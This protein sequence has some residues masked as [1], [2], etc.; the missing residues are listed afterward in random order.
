MLAPTSTD[1][2]IEQACRDAHGFIYC[3]SVTGVTSARSKL[4]SGISGLVERIRRH[5]DLPVLVGFGVSNR[6]HV[7]EIGRYAD[8]AV[9]GSALLDAIDKS[10]R[11]RAPEA[12]R[13]FV[14]ALATADT[15]PL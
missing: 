3:V 8:G 9:V 10:P 13:R 5:T 12:A 6:E 15:S 4:S 11:D 2:R 7:E 1:E 14:S